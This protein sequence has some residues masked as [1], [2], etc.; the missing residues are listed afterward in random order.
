MRQNIGRNDPCPCGSGRKYKNCCAGKIRFSFRNLPNK[1]A[2]L[3]GVL[4]VVAIAVFILAG[5]SGDGTS[6]TALQQQ[7]S[8]RSAADAPGATNAPSGA[9]GAAPEPYEYDAA[10]NQH[11]DPT[12]NHWHAGP[13]PPPGSR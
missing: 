1:P 9:D 3:V 12:H 11:F 6:N 10:N 7:A 4:S 2:W 13:P 8:P 5:R